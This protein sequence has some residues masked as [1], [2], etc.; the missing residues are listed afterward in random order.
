MYFV[1]STLAKTKHKN[2]TNKKCENN[3]R[4]LKKVASPR[5]KRK[6]MEFVRFLRSKISKTWRE[7]ANIKPK[8]TTN[9]IM[10]IQWQVPSESHSY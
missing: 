8:N 1:N 2:E 4:K 5:A 3:G 10:Q 6:L 9:K 7:R